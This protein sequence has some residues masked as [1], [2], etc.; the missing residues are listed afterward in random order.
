M[1]K[2]TIAQ[3]ETMSATK[4]IVRLA[5]LGLTSA[6]LLPML[7]QFPDDW[8]MPDMGAAGWATPGNFVA[9]AGGY[10]HGSRELSSW[11]TEKMADDQKAGKVQYPPAFGQFP[12]MQTRD[13]RPLPFGYGHGSGTIQKWLTDKAKEVYNESQ[14]EFESAQKVV[15]E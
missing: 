7:P 5:L 2:L 3:K 8:G 11:I 6:Q 15:I 12:L 1:G 4:L 13:Y 10:G 9:L 14:E